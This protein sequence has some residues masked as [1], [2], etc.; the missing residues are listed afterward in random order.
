MSRIK[1]HL[2]IGVTNLWITP[3]PARATQKAPR[4]S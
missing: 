4:A 1:A 3:E 2:L